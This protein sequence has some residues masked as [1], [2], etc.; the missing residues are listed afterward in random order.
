MLMRAYRQ[1]HAP[2]DGARRLSQNGLLD[3]MAQVDSSYSGRY[4]HSTV[5]RWESGAI[6]PTM[7]RLEVFGLALGLSPAEIDGLISLAG[8]DQANPESDESPLAYELVKTDDALSASASDGLYPDGRAA[9]PRGDDHSPYSRKAVPYAISRFFLPGGFVAIVGYFLALLGWNST[10]VLALYVGVALC[11]L[12]VQGLLRLHRSDDLGELLFVTVFFQLSIPLLHAPLTR[13]DAYG[14]YSI[15]DF[16]GTSVPITLSLIVNL[17]VATTAGLMFNSLYSWQYSRPSGERNVLGSAAWI[18]LPPIALVYGFLLAFSNVAFWI[19]GLGL[20]TLIAGVL[21]TLI[22]LRDV[23]SGIGEWD[24][25]FMLCTAT[26]ITIVLS[27]VGLAAIL[28]TYLQ[29][30]SYDMSD[31]GLFY[32]WSTDFEALGYPQHEYFERSRLAALWTSLTILVYMVVVMGGRLIFGIYG[33]GGGDSSMLRPA[34]TAASP[35][36]SNPPRT[37]RRSRLD[38]RHR[39]GWTFALRIARLIRNP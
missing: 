19:I 5:A 1:S 36:T 39:L 33:L 3:L 15:G 29:P 20:F 13:M 35:K 14:L 27:A 23:G 18:V 6:R 21:A 9:A 8:L 28:V 31:Q 12:T 22:V 26:S 37:R 4:D 16:A 34:T 11:T 32:S 38:I 2:Q 10:F 30:S 24:R 7:E 17:L 25:K